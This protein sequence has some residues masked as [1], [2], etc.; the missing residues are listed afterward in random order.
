MIPFP[1]TTV[2]GTSSV[3]ISPSTLEKVSRGETPLSSEDFDTGSSRLGRSRGT[4]LNVSSVWNLVSVSS[5][6]RHDGRF[7]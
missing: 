6:R 2:E 7:D 3:A 4:Q 1:F 5:C